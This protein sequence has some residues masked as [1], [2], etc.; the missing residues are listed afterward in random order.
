MTA[1]TIVQHGQV[2]LDGNSIPFKL[3]RIARR[4]HVHV[5]VDDDGRLSV[6]APWRFS[7]SLAHAAI[8]E[9]HRWVMKSLRSA[10]ELRRLR[11][12]L[13]SGS[14]LPL[15]DE[16]LVLNVRVE[17]QLSLLP[18]RDLHFSGRGQASERLAR[19]N[20][21]VYRNRRRLCV[22]LNSLEPGV[23]RE[24]LEAWFRRQASERLPERLHELAQRLNVVPARVQI[25]AQKSRWGSC[26]SS[27]DISL[28]W[29]LV[30][31]PLELA[32]YVLVHELCHLRHMDH[33]MDFWSLVASLIPDYRSRRDRIEKLQPRLAL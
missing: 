24:L 25:R 27:G 2:S 10:A 12:A 23:L 29:R 18:V 21:T 8:A 15:L 16:R 1:R 22:E 33:S 32:D 7:L 9:H 17:A 13:V 11:P 19:R 4:K 6:R 5:L 31:L 30:M 20:G 14:E 28:N 3:I 26:S